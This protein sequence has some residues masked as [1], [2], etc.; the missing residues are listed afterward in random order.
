[1]L[2]THLLDS[3]FQTLLMWLP[4]SLASRRFIMTAEEATQIQDSAFDTLIPHLEPL[5]ITYEEIRTSYP[6]KTPAELAEITHRLAGH[7]ERDPQLLDELRKEAAATEPTPEQP[8]AEAQLV[9]D[10]LAG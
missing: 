8:A 3:T 10:K 2:V 4:G 9:A 1:M 7:V 5:H 6:G